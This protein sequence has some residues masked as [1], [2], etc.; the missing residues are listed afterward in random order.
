MS[1]P[2]KP[3]GSPAEQV[4]L[5]QQEVFYCSLARFG[6]VQM[7]RT[8]LGSVRAGREFRTLRA[9]IQNLRDYLRTEF[10][11]LRHEVHA[12]FQNPRAE[13]RS[14]TAQFRGDL[15]GL[16]KDIQAL[17]VRIARIE[18]FLVG[19]FAARGPESA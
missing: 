2:D 13:V 12:D 10:Q 14:D 16:R 9:V 19:Y 3:P 17:N 11:G 8:P 4:G 7:P 18:G 1:K 6:H 15:T 5:P